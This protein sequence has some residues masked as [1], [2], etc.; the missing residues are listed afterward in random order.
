MC[1]QCVLHC[2]R[3]GKLE[4]HKGGQMEETNP[5]QVSTGDFKPSPSYKN[6][7]ETEHSLLSEVGQFI[8]STAPKVHSDLQNHLYNR[9]LSHNIIA[10]RK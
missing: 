10:A 8:S 1:L 5:P 2:Y 9:V 3:A 4:L 7:L 6:Q